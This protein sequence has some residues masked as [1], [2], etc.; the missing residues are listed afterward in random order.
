M[1]TTYESEFVCTTHKIAELYVEKF[2]MQYVSYGQEAEL[3]RDGEI[4]VPNLL[5]MGV[6]RQALSA[7]RDPLV[8]VRM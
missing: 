6:E 4:S 7:I 8:V 2:S 3:L 1:R 5:R